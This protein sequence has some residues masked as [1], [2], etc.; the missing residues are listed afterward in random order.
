MFGKKHKKK[1][2]DFLSAHSRLDDLINNLPFHRRPKK[3][4]PAII[5]KF[6]FR[7]F[8]AVIILSVVSGGILLWRYRGLYD[9]AISG[10][11]SL[12]E[13]IASAK[14]QDFGKMLSSAQAATD[15]F[16]RFL[17]EVK[18][19][20]ANIILKRLSL[21][22]NELADLEH[23]LKALELVSRSL[24]R[25]ALI[26]QEISN[27]SSG[28]RGNNFSE[29]SLEEKK[30]LLKTI[31]ESGPEL[32]GV[33]ANIDLALMEIQ[34]IKGYGI[35]RPLKKKIKEAEGRMM[36][37]SEAVGRISLASEL[38]PEIFGYPKQSAF[39]VLFQNSDELRPTGGF[40]GTYGILE[41]FNGDIVRFDTHDIYHMD[42]PLE[43]GKKMSLVPPEPI[44]LYLNNKWYMRDSNW[45]P[46]WPTSAEKVLWFYYK[47]DALLPAKDQINRFNGQ[48]DGVVAITPD[49]V[50]TLLSIIGPVTV[51]GETYD[52]NNF[53]NLLEYKVEQDY[54][55]QD[56]S[57]W[58]RKEVIGDILK[59]IKI[60]LFNLPHS[61]W[62]DLYQKFFASG[63]KREIQV[64]L[65]DKYL[66]GL[67]QEIG[68]G[69]EM[70]SFDGDYW[71]S[72]DANLGARKSDSIVVK[73]AEY[74][75]RNS[76]DG[77]RA[78]LTL[79]YSHGGKIDWRTD[80]YK[81]YTRVYVP[82]GSRLIKVSGIAKGKAEVG[83][84]NGKTFFGGFFN[85][86]AGTSGQ[87]VFEYKLP[88]DLSQKAKKGEYQLY[89]QKQAGSRL[90]D[91]KVDFDA[92]Y[93]VKSYDAAG[94][95]LNGQNNLIWSSQ[96]LKDKE[97]KI[98]F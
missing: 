93:K 62:P 37:A 5:A 13:T 17:S 60:R 95:I 47:E 80:D 76:S 12:E 28:I 32:N 78:K 68:W 57:S 23:L 91:V 71:F 24:E 89:I 96:L 42:M 44:K 83:E 90:N 20:R 65:K 53:T 35:L 92:G 36:D 40:L 56:V 41:T 85:I 81:T 87:A 66:N 61:Q 26:G 74:Q 64:Y 69:G 46:D 25:T 43:A 38:A 84:E 11:N 7:F 55:N 16:S 70:K 10:K 63:E 58:K 88:D 77:L 8:I 72:V 4:W 14:G 50:K 59:E 22:D 6:L 9:L 29:F 30:F 19:M 18:A 54:A 3:N 2:I 51:K 97:L 1:K 52:Q 15:Y 98:E 33:K 79:N 49:V 94:G 86:K 31:Y 75:V 48:F 21:A 73:K 39:L 82:A 34:A 45:S 27:V 67:V